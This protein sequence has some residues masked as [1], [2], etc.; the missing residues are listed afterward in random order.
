MTTNNPYAAFPKL[1]SPVEIVR[2]YETDFQREKFPQEG[3]TL[4]E[5]REITARL[6]PDELERFKEVIEESLLRRKEN[7]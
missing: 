1:P 3:R 6:T 5:W 2:Y 4:R 7:E